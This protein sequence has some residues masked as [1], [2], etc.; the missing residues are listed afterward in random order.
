MCRLCDGH[1]VECDGHMVE[2]DGHMVEYL[3]IQ[4]NVIYNI[5]IRV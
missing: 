1:M 2:C 3:H 5:P 4:S